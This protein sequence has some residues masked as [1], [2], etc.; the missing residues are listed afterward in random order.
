MVEAEQ[1]QNRGV[2]V[3]DVDLILGGVE[4][5]FVGFAECVATLHAAG[6]GV[7][8]QSRN[9]VN[10]LLTFSKWLLASEVMTPH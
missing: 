8:S 7:K 9:G 6:D 1:V 4:G 2:Q 10:T 3:V 5:E